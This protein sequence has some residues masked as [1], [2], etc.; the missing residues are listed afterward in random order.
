MGGTHGKNRLGGNSL[1]DCVVFG[2]IAGRNASNYL[3]QSCLNYLESDSQ[4]KST[5]KS[6]AN[7]VKKE[8][9][10]KEEEK[11]GSEAYKNTF[12]TLEEVAKHSTQ[13]DCWVAVNGEVLN[14]TSFLDDHPGGQNAILAYA[15]KDATE[16]F[17]MFHPKDTVDE[18]APEV[19]I[20]L[21]KI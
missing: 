8:E 9:E 7:H 12:Y 19:K 18:Y 1:L 15:G 3:F 13:E 17:N 5:L 16:N 2:R 11:K 21:L 10:P 20:G 4:Y 6:I 14:V